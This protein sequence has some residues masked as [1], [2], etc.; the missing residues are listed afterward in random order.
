MN[1]RV[2][3]VLVLV[4]AL[5]VRCWLIGVLKWNSPNG[6]ESVAGLMAKHIAEGRDYPIFFYGQSYFGALEPYLNA[7]LF[8]VAGFVP[9]LIFVLPVIFGVAS[10]W[11]EYRLV[12]KYVGPGV[13]LASAFVIALAPGALLNGTLS[14]A[15]GFGLALLLELAAVALFLKLYYADAISPSSFWGFSFISG[16]LFWVWQIYIPI[17]VVLVLLWIT[18]R[19]HIGTR[20]LVFGG[21]LFVAASSPLWIYNLAHSGATF[22]EV[23]VKFAAADTNI[24]PLS[25]VKTFV[26]NRVW[27]LAAYVQSWLSSLSGGNLVLLVAMV[28]GIGLTLRQSKPSNR[29]GLRLAWTWLFLAIAIAAFLVGHRSPRYLYILP[30]LLVPLTLAGWKQLGRLTSIGILVV[31]VVTDLVSI[32]QTIASVPPRTDWSALIATLKSNHLSYGYSDFWN[33]YPIT[34]L[35]AE[36]IIVAPIISTYAGERTDRYRPYTVAVDAAPRAFALVPN[37]SPDAPEIARLAEK[38]PAETGIQHQNISSLQ[39]YFPLVRDSLRD[40][41]TSQETP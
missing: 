27:N 19:P 39:L 21:I 34:F 40:W 36:E 15:G 29:P 33:A 9:N 24:G 37:D 16:V 6:D 18:R 30:F 11:V 32:N 23:F 1:R 31:V 22:T 20:L 10:V 2:G 5:I 35:S 26:G 7:L 4:L 13:A 3:L 38:I 28:I 12:Q 14:A 25:F 41:L 8:R 17:F